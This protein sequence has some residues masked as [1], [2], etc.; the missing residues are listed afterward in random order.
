MSGRIA[1]RLVYWTELHTKLFYPTWVPGGW[2][3]GRGMLQVVCVCGGVGGCVGVPVIDVYSVYFAA[4]VGFSPSARSTTRS[5]SPRGR[6]ARTTPPPSVRDVSPRPGHT[7]PSG[8]DEI[9]SVCVYNIHSFLPLSSPLSPTLYLSSPLF[10]T[11][12][13]IF[14]HSS[15]L[16]L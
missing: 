4:S 2:N 9:V 7:D 14:P 10:P 8:G 16:A 3:Q 12:F 15:T 13:P 5:L 6:G 1:H 11:L